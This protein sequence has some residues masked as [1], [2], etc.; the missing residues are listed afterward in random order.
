VLQ[1][2]PSQVDIRLRHGEQQVALHALRSRGWA[3]WAGKHLHL[4]AH[5]KFCTCAWRAGQSSALASL[6]V[7]GRPAASGTVN[8]SAAKKVSASEHLSPRLR[9]GRK[10]AGL[11]LMPQALDRL[12]EGTARTTA[13][14]MERLMPQAHDR[15]EKERPAQQRK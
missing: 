11:W 12:E 14:I 10:C 7:I 1:A 13:Q 6:S 3:A 2:Q 5:Y 8:A 15:L 9:L 4:P